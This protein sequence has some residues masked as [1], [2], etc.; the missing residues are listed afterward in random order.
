MA[1]QICIHGHFYQPPRDN[2]WLDIVP[3]QPSAAPAHDWNDRIH[4]ECYRANTA[5]RVLDRHGA[6]TEAINTYGWIS[7]DFGPTLVRWLRRHAPETLQAIVHADREAQERWGEGVAMAQAYNHPILPLC[8]DR[9]LRTQIRWGLA[10]F[11]HTFGR[12]ARGMWLP[13]CAVD[14]RTLEALAEQEVTFTVLAPQQAKAVISPEGRRHELDPGGPDPRRPYQVELPSGAR[15]AVFIYDGP[16][17]QAVAFERLL[18]RGDALYE[19]LRGVAPQPDQL[20]SIATDGES[21]GHHHLKGEMALAWAIRRGRADDAILPYG[22]FLAAHPPT[23]ALEIHSPSSWSCVHGVERW[24][25]DCGCRTGGPPR[26]RQAWRGPLRRAFDHLRAALDLRYERDASALLVDPWAARDAYVEVLLE[27][28]KVEDWLDRHALR[29]LSASERVRARTL[30]EIQHHRML[31]YTSCAWFFDDLGGLEP[32]QNLAYARYAIDLASRLWP[33]EDL[34]GPF[35]VDLELARSNDPSL[36]TGVDL[37]R[38]RVNPERFDALRAAAHRELVNLYLPTTTWRCF[39]FREVEQIQRPR[40]DGSLRIVRLEV[41]EAR[42]GHQTSVIA[43]SLDGPERSWS[44]ARPDTGEALEA[45]LRALEPEATAT[46][47]SRWPQVVQGVEQLRTLDWQRIASAA[48]LELDRAASHMGLAWRRNASALPNPDASAPSIVRFA[49]SIC[50]RDRL[51]EALRSTQPISD[52]LPELAAELRSTQDLR[53]AAQE[54]LRA[55]T[56]A[57]DPTDP[58]TAR[59]LCHRIHIV[60]RTG[61][62]P[63]LWE[64]QNRALALLS[65]PQ[66]QGESWE[67][68]RQELGQTLRVSPETGL[69]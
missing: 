32:V 25:A 27:P 53:E 5:A 37:M 49:A 34:L 57:L 13:E 41:R 38:T 42:T 1:G 11:E 17:S 50:A 22:P 31:M 35:L 40:P 46:V 23:W 45:I 58:S 4:Q 52:D 60:R 64:T 6:I 9:D 30:L 10:D 43:A 67:Q 65:E 19:R 20:A 61:L 44:A 62:E 66:T 15:I 54:G 55:L 47:L 3:R 7:F 12:R 51:R 2:P 48:T 68:A 14:L 36:G 21:Y 29:P 63:D 26:F 18:E 33:D 16:V 39:S 28:H 59:A 56:Q 8:S 69:D 24:R